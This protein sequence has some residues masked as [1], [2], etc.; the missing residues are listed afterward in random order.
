M[1]QGVAIRD[2]R[3]RFHRSKAHPGIQEIRASGRTPVSSQ[4]PM[5]EKRSKMVS[6]HKTPSGGISSCCLRGYPS[7]V[8]LWISPV[9]P[10]VC[11]FSNL[12]VLVEYSTR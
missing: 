11:F 2:Q 5:V 12:I 9:L 3:I 1:D 7:G 4:A 10:H 8:D 6:A